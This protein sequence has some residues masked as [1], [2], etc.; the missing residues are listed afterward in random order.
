MTIRPQGAAGRDDAA[1]PEH[2]GGTHP[3]APSAVLRAQVNEVVERARRRLLELQSEA[4]PWLSEQ[5]TGVG[6]DTEDLLFREFVGLR[7]AELTAAAAGW[8]RSR[9]HADGSWLTGRDRRGDL[10]VSVLAY[11]A[12]RLAG[13]QPDDY[14]MAMAAGWIRDA[15]GVAAAG[16]AARIWLAMFGQADWEE[17]PVPPPEA[18][19][20]PASCPVRLAGIAG[21]GRPTVLPLSVIAALRPQRALPFGLAELHGPAGAPGQVLAV[22]PARPVRVTGR[23]SLDRALQAYER[24]LEIQPLGAVRAAALRACADWVIEAQQPDGS[25]RASRSG[26]LFSLAA[27]HLLGY[28][29]DHP[30]LARGVAG[31]ERAAIWTAQDGEQVR[32]LENA[33]PAIRDTALAVTALADAGMPSDHPRLAAAGSWLLAEDISAR[34][35]WLAGQHEAGAAGLAAEPGSAAP[36]GVADTA[37]VLLALRRVRLPAGSG[38]L[39]AATCS[40]RWLAGLQRKDGGWGRFAAGPGSP[41]LTRLQLFDLRNSREAASAELT[42]QVLQAMSAAGQPGTRPIRHGVGWLLRLQLPDGAWPGDQG[43]GDLPATCAAVSALAAA[44]VVAT[45]PSVIRATGWLAQHQNADGGWGHGGRGGDSQAAGA[46]QSAPVPTAM[47]VM[48]LLA[49]LAIGGKDP[50]ASVERGVRWLAGAQLPDGRWARRSVGLSG[51]GGPSG[52]DDPAGRGGPS[53]R[54]DSVGRCGASGAGPGGAGPG[55]GDPGHEGAS[56][57]ELLTAPLSAIGR[58]Q[59]VAAARAV[60]AP[61]GGGPVPVGRQDPVAG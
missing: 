27:L 37:A 52:R 3:A 43:I 22:Q 16:L 20:L 8:I 11:C 30:A 56:G 2:L 21:W 10:S 18:V 31:L 26:W 12:L 6:P 19:Y 54:D 13:D 28:T 34:A 33:G 42:G 48:A 50:A 47:A 51:R 25:W 53:G 36:A 58:Y 59:T 7:T 55:W 32:R 35:G 41:L 49:V 15:G 60:P 61:R 23:T 46:G 4:G 39:A 14:H 38:Q 57:I 44:G 29:H 17:L 9:Q 45:K 5:V 1:H 40:L 24:S